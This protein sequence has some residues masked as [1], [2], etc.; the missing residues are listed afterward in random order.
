MPSALCAGEG[1]IWV[2]TSIPGGV[3]K[4]D[5]KTGITIGTIETRAGEGFLTTGAGSVWAKNDYSSVVS[6][7]DTRPTR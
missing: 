1:S 4:L 6:R 2:S 7:I 3:S 5:P